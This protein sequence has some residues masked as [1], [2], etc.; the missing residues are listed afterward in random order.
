MQNPHC[1]GILGG[2]PNH[3]I[4]FVGYNAKDNTLYGH[5]P[6]TVFPTYYPSNQHNSSTHGSA[7]SSNDFPP[8]DLLHQIHVKDFVTLDLRY[9]DPS[10]AICFYFATRE[11]FENFSDERRRR[12]AS[13]QDKTTA[14][15]YQIEHSPPSY[16]IES[17]EAT[18]TTARL[19]NTTGN[20]GKSSSGLLESMGI[21]DDDEAEAPATKDISAGQ[22]GK[23]KGKKYS[24]RS[25]D[26]D[27][28][29]YVFL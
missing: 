2:R 5:D 19:L 23:K 3:A 15:L 4:Y 11:E 26:E 17:H 12:L 21:I 27:D 6:H 20:I 8:E 24:T 18:D 13:R 10:M 16:M 14:V 1:I 7:S 29:E 28:T 22:T 25:D 9:L